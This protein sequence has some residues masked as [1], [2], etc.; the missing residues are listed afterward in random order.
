LRFRE[1]C[2]AKAGVRGGSFLDR[3]H[4][5]S[6]GTHPTCLVPETMKRGDLR[7]CQ[8][9]ALLGF[10]GSVFPSFRGN[11]NRLHASG[12][13]ACSFRTGILEETGIS[14]IAVN[15]PNLAR[16]FDD[17]EFRDSF[18]ARP[19]SWKRRSAGAQPFSDFIR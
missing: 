7:L 14:G 11:L 8:V 12:A 4:C 5:N 13:T 19:T 15:A 2:G 16:A 10:K 3:S 18:A 9:C 17:T 6:L 1:L